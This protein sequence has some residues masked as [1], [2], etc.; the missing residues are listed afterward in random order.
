MENCERFKGLPS[1][2]ARHDFIG[3]IEGCILCLDLSHALRDCKSR[4][5]CDRCGGRHHSLLNFSRR[6]VKPRAR[7][8]KPVVSHPVSSTSTLMVHS[9]SKFPLVEGEVPNDASSTPYSCVSSLSDGS[10][11]PVVDSGCTTTIMLATPQGIAM[12]PGGFGRG[13][14]VRCLVGRD[15]QNNLVTMKFHERLNLKRFSGQ[16]YWFRFA[17]GPW[18]RFLEP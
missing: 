6:N 16:G 4:D 8:S 14:S 5:V 11:P 12:F 18:L 9:V 2:R 15:T 7:T 17:S 1:G 3:S 10:G 13:T